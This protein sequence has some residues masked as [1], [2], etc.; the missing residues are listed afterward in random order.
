MHELIIILIM[1]ADTTTM[2]STKVRQ[3]RS[4]AEMQFLF[5]AAVFT[6]AM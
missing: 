3:S 4:M 1:V 2:G 6:K 5:W